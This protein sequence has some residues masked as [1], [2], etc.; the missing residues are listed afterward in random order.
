MTKE[1]VLDGLQQFEKDRKCM[2]LRNLG[3]YD[4]QLLT[5]M[6][7]LTS[8]LPKDATYKERKY[9]ILNSIIERPICEVCKE[10]SVK[11]N[12]KTGKY[13]AGCCHKC[14]VRTNEHK[15]KMIDKYGYESPNSS[16]I[17]KQHKVD[18]LME[19]Y[20]VTNTYQIPSVIEK[21][22]QRRLEEH[23]DPNWN[24]REKATQ[25]YFELTGYDNASKNPIVKQQKI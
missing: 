21:G 9:C 17:V 20:H 8:L 10:N 14:T 3:N 7:E 12:C 25:T 18:N 15:Q 5:S 1:Q 6:Y 22:K 4:A 23:G 13:N 19:K 11:F 2:S 16:P 24:N